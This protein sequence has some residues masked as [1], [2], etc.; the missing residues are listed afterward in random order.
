M[1]DDVLITPASRKIEF[2]D[3]SGNIDGKI[4]LDS[5][6]NLVLTSPGGGIEIGDASS[7]I[8]IGDG[9]TNVDIIFEQNGEI[10]GTTGRTITL[11]QSDSN[12]AVNALN[13]TSGGNEVMTSASLFP[14]GTTTT[15]LPTAG[16]LNLANPPENDNHVFHPF[17]H[18]DLGHFIERGGSY[19]WAGLSS[20]PT[21]ANT[22]KLFTANDDFVQILDNTISSSTYTLTLTSL[23]KTLLYSA[24]AG[25]VFCHDTFA[26]GSMVIETS[27]DGG[28]NWTTRLTDSSSKVVY[29][30][31]FDSGGTATNAIRFTFSAAPG[32]G[33]VRISTITAYDYNSNGMENY[34]LPL[35]GGNVYGDITLTGGISIGN[36]D[37]TLTRNAAGSVQIEGHTILHN[38][39]ASMPTTTTSSGD[40]DHVLIND[41][42]FLKKISP[43]NLGIGSGGGGGSTAADDIT[44][45]DAAVNLTTTSGNITIDAQGTDT[46][47]IF[48][49]TDG[50][51]DVTALTLDMSEAGSATFNA[52]LY[53]KDNRYI[54]L[55]STALDA[56]SS[57]YDLRLRTDG[58]RGFIEAMNPD[59][60]AGLTFKS[61][62]YIFAN[63]SQT[64]TYM[65]LD[66]TGSPAL[67]TLTITSTETDAT[68]NPI[69]KLDRNSASPAD[70]DFLG[71][72]RFNGRNDA[73]EEVIYA[74]MVAKIEDAS[75]ATEDGRLIY[76]V[77][78]AGSLTT[79]LDI[80]ADQFKINNVSEVLFG[81]PVSSL[82]FEG[83]TGDDFE[84]TL[85]ITDPTADRTITLPDAAGTIVL[86]DSGTISYGSGHG[87]LSAPSSLT[88][89]SLGDINLNADGSDF[90]FKMNN[91]EFFRITRLN[92]DV[93][94]KPIVD[95]KDIIFQQRDGTEVARIEDNGTFNVVSNK[96]A[97]NGTA[98]TATAAEINSA[99][100]GGGGASNLNGLSDVTISSVANNDLLK[101]NSTA[102]E[103]QNTNLG[104]TVTPTLSGTSS[105]YNDGR[106]YIVTVSN[107]STYDL[108]AY[109]VVIKNSSNAIVYNMDSAAG[110]TELIEIET[111]D[112]GRTTGR[113]I[114]DA[115]STSYFQGTSNN[116]K[117]YTIEVI[118][119][120]FG[121][122]QSETA[123]LSVTVANPPQVTLTAG[124]YRYYRVT[125]FQNQ[126]WF[127]GWKLY[128][129][130]SQSGTG[131]PTTNPSS[132]ATGS[133]ISWTSDSQTNVA[134]SNY[135]RGTSYSV[136]K[137][138]LG[139]TQSSG[140]WT[141]G[142]NLT[143]YWV[144]DPGSGNY[145]H[146]NAWL[147]LD[148]GTARTINSMTF[149]FYCYSTF[150][151][152]IPKNST[153][154]FVVQG[155]NDDSSW[156]T[157][158]TATGT[159]CLGFE[160]E[161]LVTIYATS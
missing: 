66:S 14:S 38:S 114:I 158:A 63:R 146:S 100:S 71:T 65:E 83:A 97:I 31:T 103:W 139:L 26:P 130:T 123:T 121:D 131:Y 105:L 143:T 51:A 98:I 37:T 91:A 96:L 99:A 12:I 41:G 24:Y 75:D 42:G 159:D 49:G 157:I 101:Y 145:T 73:A 47:I 43:A 133:T 34:F 18:N 78:K 127:S 35:R 1:S 151:A 2:K 138:F 46:D 22:K 85:A 113:I 118:A 10:R 160:S 15:G 56:S 87:T 140:W 50:P 104:L 30:C 117:Q 19:A 6:G 80:K 53:L 25:I 55:G 142:S 155:S 79:V 122:L 90:H 13:F 17:L 111:D 89:T 132:S 45:G 128:S 82:K 4:E 125:S 33:E 77:M 62:D 40:A 106:D 147:K 21:E 7:D 69:L 32:S 153:T 137:P 3:S 72:V 150:T 44:A 135:Y 129:G 36:A 5:A 64:A 156:T 16:A 86:N 67:T 148:L 119:Q 136:S 60:G 70:A 144:T 48:K 94:M 107:H 108:P 54:G 88:L 112:E 120:D 76:K 57:L 58:V 115:T 134:S 124:S 68:A 95:G 102:G 52:H 93:I 161:T 109:S 59:S 20:N 39:N 29:A 149:V 23:P 92:D 8:F 152:E 110:S 116:G 27:T 11:G 28:S 81:D 74:S 141:L 61:D 9:S 126:V 84:T 154:A